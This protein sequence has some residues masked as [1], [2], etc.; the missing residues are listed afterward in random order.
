MRV[1]LAL[2]LVSLA[3]GA[4]EVLTGAGGLC[5]CIKN[6]ERVPCSRDIGEAY[7]HASCQ[8]P[9]GLRREL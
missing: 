8:K 1:L 2:L 6:G 7:K 3:P 5:G 9:K 4:R